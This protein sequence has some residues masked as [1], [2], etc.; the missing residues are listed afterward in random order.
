[1]GVHEI[2]G[3]G[4][5]V[6]RCRLICCKLDRPIGKRKFH[7]FQAKFFKAKVAVLPISCY[8]LLSTLRFPIKES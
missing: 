7:R 4:C 6:T 2:L 8:I 1:M 3:P 5:N